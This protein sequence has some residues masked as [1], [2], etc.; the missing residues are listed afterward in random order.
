MVI[1]R[2]GSERVHD[3][4]FRL[5]QRR[6]ARGRPGRVTCVD[7]ANVF[8]SMA[9]F[10]KIFDER[11]RALPRRSRP[12]TTTSTRRRS[13]WCASPGTFDVIVTENMFGDILSDQTAALVGGMG[14]APSGDIGDDHALFQPCHGSAPDIAGQGKAN[15]TATILSAAM[16][17]DWLGERRGDDALRRRGDAARARGR[18]RLRIRAR[19]GRS[20]SAAATAR[21]R[22]PRRSASQPVSARARLRVAGIGAG[23]FSRFHLEAGARSRTPSSS[24]GATPTRRRRDAAGESLGIGATFTDAAANARRSAARPRGHR[25][26][27]ADASRAGRAGGG[28]QRFRRSAR[29]RSRRRTT[30]PSRS[31]MSPKRRAIPLAVHENFR[32]QPW[33]REAKRLSTSGALGTPHSVAFRLRPGDGQGPRRLP[34]PPAVLPADA[35]VPRLRNRDPLRSTRSAS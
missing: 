1:T 16:M 15:P 4:A 30:K 23:Y 34:R 9:F 11:A 2:A 14:M 6:K 28:A 29:R 7:K 17:L 32:W 10:R 24:A 8:R 26:A 31:S 12:T 19:A 3:F 20:S 13:T 21:A 18:R 5:A 22:S 33:Y 25:D 27:A 35:A